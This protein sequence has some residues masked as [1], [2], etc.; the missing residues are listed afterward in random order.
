[1]F[2][3]VSSARTCSFSLSNWSEITMGAWHCWQA[4]CTLVEAASIA[5]KGAD[6]NTKCC[7][8]FKSAVSLGFVS[9]RENRETSDVKHNKQT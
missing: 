3:R 1:M 9:V 6:Q 8:C 2:L 7:C 5:K 4:K